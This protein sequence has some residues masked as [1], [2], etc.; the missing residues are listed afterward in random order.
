MS[1]VHLRNLEVP[2]NQRKNRQGLLITKGSAYGHHGGCQHT[3]GKHTHTSIHLPIQQRPQTR[4][5]ERYGSSS[6][7][8]PTPQRS[9]PMEHGEKEVTPSFTQGRA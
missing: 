3:E 2:R 1:P 9:I 7:A 4:G 6:S 8:L 5:L